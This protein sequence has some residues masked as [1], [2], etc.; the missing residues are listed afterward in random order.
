MNLLN[1]RN[2][3]EIVVLD[4][5]IINSYEYRKG[6]IILSDQSVFKINFILHDRD[7]NDFLLVCEP[8]KVRE[9]NISF[10]S[11]EIEETLSN[12]ILFT[13]KTYKIKETFDK[14]VANGKNYL[15]AKTLIFSNLNTTHE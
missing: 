6:L 1:D 9:F 5:I 12:N 2:V 7:Q 4:F 10:N 8:I 14:I 3:D 15:L 11:F 13:I